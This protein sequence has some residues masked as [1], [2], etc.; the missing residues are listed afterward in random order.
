MAKHHIVHMVQVKDLPYLYL[1][2]EVHV[3]YFPKPWI[4]TGSATLASD[5]QLSFAIKSS[6]CRRQVE[7]NSVAWSGYMV[8]VLSRRL[9]FLKLIQ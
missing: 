7:M 3:A 1:S 2:E 5:I 9:V 4:F 6:D 8:F